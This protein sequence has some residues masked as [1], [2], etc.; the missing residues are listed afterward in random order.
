VRKLALLAAWALV[1]CSKDER[2]KPEPT[3]TTT[4]PMV[5]AQGVRFVTPSRT[6]ELAVEV[7]EARAQAVADGRSLIVYVGAKWCEPCQRFHAAAKSGQLD[8]EFPN[9]SVLEY[10]LDE[11]RD[12][13]VAAG[14][15]SSM[16]PLFVVPRADGR[17]SERR[18]E[19]SVKGDQALANITPRLR[20]LLG[21]P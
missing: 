10:D 18:F 6:S 13:L 11:E 14:Y 17:A 20:A 21:A 15:S 19:G 4:P 16:I 9:L 1:A 7:R 5:L 12:R 2:A 3:T 8:A